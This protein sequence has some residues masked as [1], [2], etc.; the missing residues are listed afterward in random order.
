[1]SF[2]GWPGGSERGYVGAERDGVSAGGLSPLV[3]VWCAY[4]LANGGRAVLKAS[5]W[6]I[7]SG[8][9]MLDGGADKLCC[10]LG[11]Y[12]EACRVFGGIGWSKRE[13]Q[14][15]RQCLRVY[16][17]HKVMV[18]DEFVGSI[19]RKLMRAM[20][21]ADIDIATLIEQFGDYGVLG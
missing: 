20:Q 11:M 14:T 21:I 1:M 8:V 3:L 9:R 10:R 16:Q 4:A 18:S 5:R 19:H 15:L 17:G 2:S 6:R 7:E 13:K 12:E